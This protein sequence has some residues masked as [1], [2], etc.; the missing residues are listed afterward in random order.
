MLAHLV[1]AGG[2]VQTDEVDAQRLQGGQGGA[3]LGAEQHDA[4]R[5]EGEGA[6]QRHVDAEGVHGP[7][8]ADD[9]GLGLQQVLGGLDDQ[10]VG[11]AREEALGVLLV[12]V[13]QDV[14]RDVAERGQ[15][16][17]GAD[18]A[19]DPALTAVLRAELVG[20]LAGDAGAGLGELEDPVGDLVLVGGGVVRAEGVGLHAVDADRE[21]LLV[22]GA[23]DV[24][25]GDVEDLVAAFEV[26][27]VLK[28][29]VLRLEHGAHRSVGHHHPGGERLAQGCCAGP[30]VGGGCR[31]RGH[32]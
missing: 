18:R 17:A 23:H 27:E 14:V 12:A 6:D 11:A 25:A 22:D 1:R 4:G 30:A 24:G 15:L 28:G 7:A 21:V 9:A 5:L 19:E 2:A 26:L 10:G 32:G 8:G 3:D 13:A 16:G 20:D 29:R 31:Q